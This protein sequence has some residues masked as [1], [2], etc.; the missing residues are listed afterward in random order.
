MALWETRQGMIWMPGCTLQTDIRIRARIDFPT[1]YNV[2]NLDFDT[3]YVPILNCADAVAAKMLVKYAIR[4]A[5]DMLAAAMQ[6][7]K[8]QMDKIFLETVR[9]LQK[10][11]NQRAEFG[12]EAVQ[13]FAIA[14]GWL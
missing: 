3:T 8:E 9:D 14:W 4:F 1:T 13:D 12:A 5:P 11:E 10:N 7:E 6:S 2:A